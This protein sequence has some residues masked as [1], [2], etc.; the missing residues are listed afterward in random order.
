MIIKKAAWLAAAVIAF[1]SISLAQTGG[2]SGRVIG[3]DGKPQQGAVIKLVRT[4]ITATY[5]TK[6]NKKGEWGYYTLP[7]GWYDVIVEVDG[8]DVDAERKVHVTLSDNMTTIIFD[9]FK[10]K[11]RSD[12]LTRAAQAGNLTKEQQKSMTEQERAAF[13]QGKKQREAQL[14]KSKSL[15]DAFNAGMQSLECGKKPATC[16]APVAVAG[17]PVAPPLTA[18]QHFE[19]AIM[20]FNRAAQLDPTQAAI[21]PN[22]ADAYVGL[23]NSKTGADKDAALS[24]AA[25]NYEKALALKP[26]TAAYHNNYALILARQ[27]KFPEAQAELQKAAEYDPPGGGKYYYNLGVLLLNAGQ[28][29][30]ATDVF[31]KAI[32]LTPNYAEAHYRYALCLSAKLTT[33]PDGK[34]IAPPGM[35]E[36]LQKYLEL[37]P[38]G[39]NAGDAKAMLATLNATVQTTYENPNA[40]PPPAKKSK[41]K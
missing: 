17:Q 16:P 24:S 36:E 32:E 18:G 20:A 4:D 26:T 22:L 30:P 6:T 7:L 2:I 37:A 13:E 34:P 11:Q 3:E 28:Y 25:E 19:E 10:N 40:P 27:G 35:A 23:A 31:K 39:P 21:W 14:S 29:G 41:K 38:A 12:E 33:G 1:V 9:L 8:K 15:N 5:K